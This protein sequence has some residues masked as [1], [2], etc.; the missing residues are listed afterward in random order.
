MHTYKIFRTDLQKQYNKA[1]SDYDQCRV[2][3]SWWKPL[4]LLSSP[5]KGSSLLTGFYTEDIL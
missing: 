5:Y 1:F 4:T 2:L 3:C